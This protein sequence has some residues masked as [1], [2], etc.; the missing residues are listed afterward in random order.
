MP[1]RMAAKLKG[2]MTPLTVRCRRSAIAAMMG[3]KIT[4]TGVLL[5][6]PLITRAQPSETEIAAT[7]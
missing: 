4:T 5:S 6:T 7:G 2:I 1:P 3:M